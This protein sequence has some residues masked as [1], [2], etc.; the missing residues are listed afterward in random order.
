MRDGQPGKAGGLLVDYCRRA[1]IDAVIRGVRSGRDLEHE[2]PMAHMN[3]E[4]AGIETFFLA[5]EPDQTHLSSTL[6]TVLDRVSLVAK[7][8]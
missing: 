8:M 1:G 6:V 2:L 7:R 4:L 3:R 5:A